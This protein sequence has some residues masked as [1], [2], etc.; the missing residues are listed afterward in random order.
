MNNCKV[1]NRL[2]SV[3]ICIIAIVTSFSCTI[4]ADDD[5]SSA[6]PLRAQASCKS[7]CYGVTNE[8][9]KRA[10]YT[11]IRGSGSTP[12]AAKSDHNRNMKK[13]K[14]SMPKASHDGKY[15]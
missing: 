12:A 1:R 5:A 6:E 8:Q 14:A 4:F 13:H 10:H 11:T 3:I 2:A 7:H 9:H 15:F